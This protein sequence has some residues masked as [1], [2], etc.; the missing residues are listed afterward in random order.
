MHQFKI[1]IRTPLQIREFVNLAMIQPFDVL[2]GNEAQQINGKSF[3]GMFTLDHSKPVNVT[4]RCS[5]EEY[6]SFHSAAS[7]IMA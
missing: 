6:G 7:A 1:H 5:D 3:M 4:V 2:V